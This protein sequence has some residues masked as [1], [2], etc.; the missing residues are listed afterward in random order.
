[1]T[2][3]NSQDDRARTPGGFWAFWTTLPGALTGL[4]ALITAIVAA[5]GL[6]RGFGVQE[7]LPGAGQSSGGLTS[8]SPAAGSGTGVPSASS[9]TRNGHLSIHSEDYVDLESGRVG[10]QLENSEF[11]Y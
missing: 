7:P 4:A 5:V 10:R 3:G 8:P 2:Q 9:S 6:M 1:M 11:I